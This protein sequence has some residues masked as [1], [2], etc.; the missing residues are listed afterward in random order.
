MI[1]ENPRGKSSV[2]VVCEHASC[3][4]PEAYKNLGLQ[5]AALRSHIAW[6]P[7][8]LGVARGMSA[9]LD[10]PLVA[11]G[12]SRLVYDCNRPP[13]AED[14]MPA[15]SEAIKVP[16]N[17]GLSDEQRRARAERYYAPFHDQL[18]KTIAAIPSAILATVHSFTPL[19]LGQARAVE[20]G[21]LH[22]SDARL[23]DIM[24]HLAPAHTKANVQRNA[25][26]GPEHGVTHTLKEHALKAEH[27]NVMLEIR[28]DLIQTPEQQEA[29][30]ETLVNWLTESLA[31]WN[32]ARDV[33]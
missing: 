2:V 19:F 24:L 10:A 13:S 26:Y 28:N 7:G 21:I 18:A 16:G 6:D 27:L 14:A 32:A 17:F 5:G 22:D 20:I 11:S 23:A 3:F 31:Q 12:I 1:V 4:I 30:A 9:R 33:Q 8:A 29:M 25:P 15:Q